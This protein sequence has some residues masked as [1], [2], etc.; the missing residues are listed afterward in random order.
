MVFVMILEE[1]PDDPDAF[2]KL[3]FNRLIDE[4]DKES[5]M[6]TMKVDEELGRFKLVIAPPEAYVVI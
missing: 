6:H 3:L 1:Q 2:R 4:V 5:P